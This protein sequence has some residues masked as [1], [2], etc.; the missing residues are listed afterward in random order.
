M[1]RICIGA[2]CQPELDLFAEDSCEQKLT[3]TAHI[4]IQ[5]FTQF[6]FSLNFFVFDLLR[7]V[8]LSQAR[9]FTREKHK[10]KKNDL[11]NL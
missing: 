10:N 3:S 11:L 7:H 4:M 2:E 6:F 8:N 5:I 1:H 9:H